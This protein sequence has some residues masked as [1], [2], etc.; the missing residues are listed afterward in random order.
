MI[1]VSN[2][3]IYNI[4]FLLSLDFKSTSDSNLIQD[5]DIE[6]VLEFGTDDV[7]LGW[8]FVNVL[9]YLINLSH[10]NQINLQRKIISK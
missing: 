10:K 7:E 2:C 1:K 8:N 3:L 9:I 5:N 6:G 4:T